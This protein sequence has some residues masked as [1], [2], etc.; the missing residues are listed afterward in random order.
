MNKKVG[1]IARTVLK[2]GG[3][4]LATSGFLPA[5]CSIT[6]P[7]LAQIAGVISVVF[8]TVWGVFNAQDHDELRKE[9]T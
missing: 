1:D 3:A 4:V 2:V 9:L 8:A 5:Q 7:A 6:D